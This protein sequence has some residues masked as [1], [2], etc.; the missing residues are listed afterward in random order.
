MYIIRICIQSIYLRL[1]R[2]PGLLPVGSNNIWSTWSGHH[3]C[4]H[5]GETQPHQIYTLNA[6][7][8][9]IHIFITWGDNQLCSFTNQGELYAD[10]LGKLT[11]LGRCYLTNVLLSLL[12]LLLLD[13]DGCREQHASGSGLCL[14]LVSATITPTP[15]RGHS[16]ALLP[17]NIFLP[18]PCALT[19]TLATFG[20][21]FQDVTPPI[22]RPRKAIRMRDNDSRRRMMGNHGLALLLF[23]NLSTLARLHGYV[24]SH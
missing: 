24:N 1:L 14:G 19:S 12:P 10:V 17:L 3:I 5:Y 15:M 2:E 7:S 11:K 20:I 23:Y 13:S 16:L 9:T 22:L 4:I 18:L 6:Y 21:S 8:D